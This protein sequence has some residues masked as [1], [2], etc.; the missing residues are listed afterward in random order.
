[1]LVDAGMNKFWNAN[2]KCYVRMILRFV[3]AAVETI[4]CQRRQIASAPSKEL[5]GSNRRTPVVLVE[6]ED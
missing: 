5:F 4:V 3:R 1:M 6:A 2:V